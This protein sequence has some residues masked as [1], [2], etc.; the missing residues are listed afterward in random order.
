MN[1]ETITKLVNDDNLCRHLAY[2]SGR[3]Q[4]EREYENFADYTKNMA[5]SVA[6]VIGTVSD[7]VGTKK[8]FGIKFTKDNEKFHLFLKSDGMY[9]WLALKRI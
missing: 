5:D 6:E 3:W 1:K 7:P 9:S 8:P 4:D 2:L